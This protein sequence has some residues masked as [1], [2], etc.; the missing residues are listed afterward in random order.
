MKRFFILAILP[1]AL[2][3]GCQNG[4][5]ETEQK[6]ELEGNVMAIHDEAMAKMGDIY[7]LRRQLR[8][9]RDTL[10]QQAQPD[11]AAIL[12]LQQ[13]LS[14]LNQADEVMMQ[15]MRQYKA[16]DTLQHQQAMTY[17]QQ[18]L[19]K[20]TRVQTVMDSTL[21]AAKQTLST[22]EQKK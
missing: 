1:L 9:L 22:H 8:S 5:S 10:E 12:A 6:A 20:V 11:S 14:G 7:K 21:Q 15:W 18:E 3:A 4:A 2:L 17:L 13:E 19:V 16:P